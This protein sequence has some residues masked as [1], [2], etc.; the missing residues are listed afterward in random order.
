MANF[1]VVADASSVVRTRIAYCAVH[2]CVNCHNFWTNQ[3]APPS[4]LDAAYNE[5]LSLQW[6]E[7][8]VTEDAPAKLYTLSADISHS[9]AYE[10][11]N[12]HS[13][14]SSD[15]SKLAPLDVDEYIAS[16]Y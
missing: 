2:K 7:C 8:R 12:C 15:Q 1:C 13:L 14:W 10:S 16:S 9:A 5:Q 3:Y 11:E 6:Q 4:K